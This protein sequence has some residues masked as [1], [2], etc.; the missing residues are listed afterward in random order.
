MTNVIYHASSIIKNNN[1]IIKKNYKSNSDKMYQIASC[2]KFITSLLVGKLCELNKLN[3]DDDINKYL[4][5]WK[6]NVDGITL[7]HLLSHTSGSSD[8]NGYLGME[9]QYKYEQNLELNIKIISGESYAKPF[10]I[11]EKPD[12]RFMY[13]GAGYQVVQQIIEEITGKR[14]YKLLNKYIFRPLHMKNSTGKLL[15]EK[16]HKYDIAD[17]NGLYRMYAETAAAGLFFY[18]RNKLYK[19]YYYKL[20]PKIS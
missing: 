9:P 3:Y 2:S 8:K 20:Q 15:Y 19:N 6:C 10:N 14:L 11:T 17:M 13:S 1:E 12:R 4:K 5:K 7:R 16:K 18:S